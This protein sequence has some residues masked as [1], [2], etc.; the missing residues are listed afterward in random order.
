[1]SDAPTPTLQTLLKSAHDG[2]TAAQIALARLYLDGAV[3]GQEDL[4]VG[5]YWI[6]KAADQGNGDAQYLLGSMYYNGT[7]FKKNLEK[8]A[9]YIMKAALQ[10]HGEAQF[11]LGLMYENGMGVKRDMKMAVTLM[12]MSAQKGHASAL[13]SIGMLFELGAMTPEDHVR[14]LACYRIAAKSGNVVARSYYKK[15]NKVMSAAQIALSDSISSVD[16][17]LYHI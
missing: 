5:E 3:T 1:M 6:K 8:A 7:R 9:H 14:A 13:F 4:A 17:I 10:D 2:D 11:M 12:K 16:E 15:L